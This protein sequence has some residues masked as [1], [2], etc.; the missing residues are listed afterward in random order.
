MKI[1]DFD[2]KQLVA[3]EGA[4]ELYIVTWGAHVYY[5]DQNGST[6]R[7]PWTESQTRKNEYKKTAFAF[8]VLCGFKP[9]NV[10]AELPKN[11]AYFATAEQVEKVIRQLPYL[12]K[13][14]QEQLNEIFA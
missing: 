6:M 10:S 12:D 1:T 3:K 14:L 4:D 8:A 9:T 5:A 7:S 11:K 2:S 13:E